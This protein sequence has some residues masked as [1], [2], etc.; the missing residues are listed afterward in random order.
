MTFCT[1]RKSPKTRPK[2]G[3]PPWVSPRSV[4]PRLSLSGVAKPAAAQ[5]PPAP[6][7]LVRGVCFGHPTPPRRLTGFGPGV[8]CTVRGVGRRLEHPHQAPIGRGGRVTGHLS[9]R[10]EAAVHRWQCQQAHAGKRTPHQFYSPVKQGFL[11]GKSWRTPF[12]RW[13]CPPKPPFGSFR[14]VPKGTRPGG[15]TPKSI[16]PA[17]TRRH[18]ER[19]PSEVSRPNF[20]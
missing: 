14:A 8:R 16:V 19:A 10:P 3:V 7:G 15:E 2:G 17:G 18:W 11:G 5:L 12:V 20:T 1:R 4:G 6:S 13:I 9:K